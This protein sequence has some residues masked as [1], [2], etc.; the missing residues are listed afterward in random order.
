MTHTQEKIM[1]DNKSGFQIRADLLSQAQGILQDNHQRK[2]DA[3]YMHNDSFPND[4]KPMPTTSITAS[5]V[6]TVAQELNE[7]VNQK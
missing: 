3:V 6:I 2:V 4:K 1:S 5:D 7:F